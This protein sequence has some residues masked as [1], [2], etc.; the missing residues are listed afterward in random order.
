MSAARL[1][2]ICSWILP[3]VIGVLAACDTGGPPQIAIGMDGCASCGMTI[4]EANQA[5]AF[6]VDKE[7]YRFCS[8]G[9]L[10]KHHEARRRAGETPPDELYFSDYETGEKIGDGAVVFLFSNRYPN[11]MDWGILSFAERKRAVAYG[12]PG[13]KV[14]AW[15][16]LQTLRGELDRSVELTVTSSGIE[17]GVIQI[18]KGQL[19]EWV[20]RTQGLDTDI[21][22][23]LRGYEHQ[24]GAI[25]LP[26]SGE[27]VWQ[28]MMAD[29]P[30]EGFPFVRLDNDEI[31]GL[32]RIR[33]AHT[34]DEAAE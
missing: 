30:G 7:P 4:S 19:V 14:V 31:L 28:R 27:P 8:P 33:G 13:E 26:A 15:L 5:C 18:Q 17:P 22:V 32:V 21:A 16:E 9:C 25:A 34:A 29:R 3:L 23:T 10:L 1:V 6:T 24:L 2:R 11:T 20:L 12:E